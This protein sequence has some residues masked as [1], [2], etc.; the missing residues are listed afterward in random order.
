MGCRMTL[1]HLTKTNDSIF[2]E[3]LR[4]SI[5]LNDLKAILQY[6]MSLTSVML[7]NTGHHILIVKNISYAWK[8]SMTCHAIS[9]G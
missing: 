3:S 5:S 1:V 7:H 6:V 2:C 8:S 9:S 4:I